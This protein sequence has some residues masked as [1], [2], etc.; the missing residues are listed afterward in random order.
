MSNKNWKHVLIGG[1]VGLAL[2]AGTVWAVAPTAY[3]QADSD[4]T[5]AATNL[6]QFGRSDM[7]DRGRQMGGN[8]LLLNALDITRAEFQEAQQ[9]A[10]EGA[11]ARA[12]TEGELTQDEADALLA[13]EGRGS[14]GRANIQVTDADLAEALG[15]TEDELTAARDGA[16][17]QAVED[18]LLT[19][20]QANELRFQQLMQDALQAAR[21][22]AIQQGVEQGLIS[23]AQA[24]QMLSDSGM[25]FGGRGFGSMKMGGHHGV[26]PGGMERGGRSHFGAPNGAPGMGPN[27]GPRNR[28]DG[29]GAVDPDAEATPENTSLQTSI[30]L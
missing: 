24:D 19:D 30:T 10:R 13:G 14:R 29:N 12:V 5:D 4:V 17:D 1:A 2:M 9:A 21:E 23:P 25:G 16:V 11:V 28:Q 27:G 8:E 20:A 7:G 18:G 15:I 3:A 22:S 6:V 26:G